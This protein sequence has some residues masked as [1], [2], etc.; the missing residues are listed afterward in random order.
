MKTHEVVIPG[1]VEPQGLQIREREIER[2]RA[3]EVVIA[4]EAAG[5][6]YAEVQMLRGRYP[7][8]PR[9]PFVPGYDVVGRVHAIGEGVDAA[10]LGKRVATMTETGAW[11]DCTV[12]RAEELVVVPE[13]LDPCEVDTLVVNGVTAYKMLH[14]LA[15]VRAG[16]TI[17]VHG[18][19][20][21]V[22]TMLLQLA[23]LAGVRVIGTCR[24]SQRD[25]VLALGATPVDYTGGRVLD[26]VRALAPEGVDAV[27]DHVG[28]A[29][30]RASWAMLRRGGMVVS[31]GNASAASQKGGSP[32]IPIVKTMALAALWGLR[33]GG[34]SMKMFDVW[35]RGSFGAD[36]TFRPRRFWSEF[37]E[38]LGRLVEMLA[39]GEIQGHVARRVP[40]LE[41]GTAIG[42]HARGAFTG[43][44]VLVSTT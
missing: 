21:G 2:P 17:V 5:V 9:F 41:A 31:Y 37:R 25:A 10:V 24:P 8:Q 19:G 23:K 11:A 20:G 14:R 38:D 40:L 27:F 44:I 15:R 7:G 36:R 43:K 18:A 30:L 22:G 42:E 35:G 3:G 4:M 16:Q 28:G 33:P 29:S 34:R 6:S 13:A 12:R 26:E 39:R 1:I 32:W